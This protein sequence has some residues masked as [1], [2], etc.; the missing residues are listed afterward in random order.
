MPNAPRPEN[1]S[2]NIRVEDDLWH[3]AQAAA[4]KR[5]T[6]LSVYIREALVRLVREE[7]E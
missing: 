5:R 6:T 4:R 3:A 1:P 7:E 2:R